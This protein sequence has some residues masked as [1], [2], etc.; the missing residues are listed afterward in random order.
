MPS[1]PAAAPP[2]P[3]SAPS[4]ATN[5]LAARAAGAEK[6]QEV[7]KVA[8]EARKSVPK[9]NWSEATRIQFFRAL[10]ARKLVGAKR[11]AEQDWV[12]V[13]RLSGIPVSEGVRSDARILL[14]GK[15]GSETTSCTVVERHLR[16]A[17]ASTILRQL[18][19]EVLQNKCKARGMTS[20]YFVFRFYLVCL[21]CSLPRFCPSRTCS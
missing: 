3:A 16:D 14:R 11:I 6:P 21:L 10:S 17:N 12:E 9:L 18:K 5:V 15:G 20:C 1:G 4:G 7:K 19:R 8:N 2:A 13:L